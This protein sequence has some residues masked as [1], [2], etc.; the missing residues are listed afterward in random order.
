MGY[1]KGKAEMM[2]FEEQRN[3]RCKFSN[4]H[5]GATGYY[6]RTVGFNEATVAKYIWG[7]EKQ[8]MLEEK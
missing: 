8:D 7:Q 3:L 6:L 2:N 5:Y 4:K 1:L